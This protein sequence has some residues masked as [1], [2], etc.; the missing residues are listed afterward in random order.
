MKFKKIT[1]VPE[2]IRI[3]GFSSIPLTVLNIV[4]DIIFWC[5]YRDWVSVNYLFPT[6]IMSGVIL[7]IIWEIRLFKGNT[8]T[9]EKTLLLYGVVFFISEV[10]LI[11]AFNLQYWWVAPI[12]TILS[13]FFGKVFDE[14]NFSKRRGRYFY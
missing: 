9:H 7:F 5:K 10:I 2:N 6:T 14:K 1:E 3:L 13:L 12:I 8:F 4:T 11:I